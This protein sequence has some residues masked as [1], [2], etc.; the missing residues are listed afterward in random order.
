M[1]IPSILMT[2]AAVVLMVSP[3]LAN[4]PSVTPSP[5]KMHHHW[6]GFFDK[7]DT[8]HDG[9][10]SK[11][12]WVAHESATFDKIDG[13]HDGALTKDEFKATHEKM[14]ARHVNWHGRGGK[15]SASEHNQ[16]TAPGNSGGAGGWTAQ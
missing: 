16:T 10:I 1:K 5:T 4:G 13:N 12:E 11:D 6:G 3:A 2:A 14:K 7:I 8:N 15:G 9:K